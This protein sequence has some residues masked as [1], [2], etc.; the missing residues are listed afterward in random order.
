MRGP[1]ACRTRPEQL[2]WPANGHSSGKARHLSGRKAGPG[3]PW[4][5][6]LALLACFGV[7]SCRG[8]PVMSHVL[9]G[10]KVWNE[11]DDMCSAIPAGDTLPRS[12]HALEE[13][14]FTILEFLQK[15]KSLV[16]HPLLP[17]VPQLQDRRQKR[18]KVD[19]EL[20]IP[21]GVESRGY[22]MFR[23]RNGRRSTAFY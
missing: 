12:S 10:E 14:C 16:T 1:S 23:P 22:F 7:S 6:L 11:I 21:G 9:Q 19:E 13:F 5:L 2:P 4:R 17:I 8:V 3:T 18:Y 15:S 20:R